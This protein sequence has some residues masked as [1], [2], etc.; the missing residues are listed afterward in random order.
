MSNKKDIKKLALYFEKL[1]NEGK[2]SKDCFHYVIKMCMISHMEIYLEK[3][4]A[5]EA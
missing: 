5:T 1:Y 3:Q 4:N 2:I